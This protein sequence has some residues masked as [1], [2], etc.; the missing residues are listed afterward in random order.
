M[1]AVVGLGLRQLE[2]AVGEDRVVAV[3]GGQLALSL[4]G[5]LWIEAF[6]APY[7]Q[8]PVDA[9]RGLGGERGVGHLGDL[10]T[11]VGLRAVQRGTRLP[12][13]VPGTMS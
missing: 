1:A 9:V 4:R 11:L 8:P 5:G 13:A 7:D 12:G 3:G 2:Q 10:G 6:D